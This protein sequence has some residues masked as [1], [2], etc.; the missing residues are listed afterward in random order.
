[1]RR[2]A[3]ATVLAWA[4]VMPAHAD[5]MAYVTAAVQ[6]RVDGFCIGPGGGLRELLPVIQQPTVENPRRLLVADGVLYVAGVTHID[7]FQIGPNGGLTRIGRTKLGRNANP[8][9]LAIDP[10]R[11]HLYVPHRASGRVEAYPLDSATGAIIDDTDMTSCALTPATVSLQDLEVGGEAG[12]RLLYVT[13]STSLFT[14]GKKGRIDVFGLSADG[15]LPDAYAGEDCSFRC[16]NPDCTTTSTTTS[17]SLTTLTTTVT[18]S[19]TTTTLDDKITQPLSTRKKMY[20]PGPFVIS[21]VDGDDVADYL[22]V[23]DNTVRQVITFDLTGGLFTGDKQER[24]GSTDTFGRFLDLVR[25]GNTLFAASDNDGRVRAFALKLQDGESPPTP[26]TKVPKSPQRSTNEIVEST[27]IRIAV[28]DGGDHGILYIPG[29]EANRLYAHRLFEK[30][31]KKTG[32]IRLY[33][34]PRNF[35][36]SDKRKATFPNDVALAPIGTCPPE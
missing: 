7:S 25:Y 8:L 5:Q 1:M 28:T 12:S 36:K 21:D 26:P 18:T 4:L 33:P 32:E 24:A 31:D 22:Y 20:A 19:T 3:F 6:N 14:T 16:G 23:Y 2:L 29:G 30:Q 15:R 27:P 10:E 34:E 11:T 9:D 17:T 35:S 13:A